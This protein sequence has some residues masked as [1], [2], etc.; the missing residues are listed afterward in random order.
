MKFGAYKD[1]MLIP[2][3]AFSSCLVL[4]GSKTHVD[5]NKTKE[6]NKNNGNTN[7]TMLI[8]KRVKNRTWFNGTWYMKIICNKW[9]LQMRIN[10]VIM[11]AIANCR[12]INEWNIFHISSLFLDCI[13][14]CYFQ[15][16]QNQFSCIKL[17]LCHSLSSRRLTLYFQ[18]IHWEL[19]SNNPLNFQ[20][21][22]VKE[23]FI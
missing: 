18:I 13:W 15:C 3:L 9:A 11:S 20:V 22:F 21:A 8:M 1:S 12:S 17:T 10:R 6:T 2:T 4:C 7:Y 14:I 5:T 19:P 23:C 16:K